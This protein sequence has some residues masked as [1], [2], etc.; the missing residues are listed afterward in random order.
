MALALTLTLTLTQV[1]VELLAT[2]KRPY[3]LGATALEPAWLS[4]NAPSMCDFSNP[5]TDPAPWYDRERDSVLA[6]QAVRL[7][8]RTSPSRFPSPN[9]NPNPKPR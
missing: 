9:P 7:R 8:P 6:C 3:M 5:L 4:F 1:Y 2:E